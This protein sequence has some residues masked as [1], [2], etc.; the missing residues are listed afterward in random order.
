MYKLKVL[1]ALLIGLVVVPGC[2]KEEPDPGPPKDPNPYTKVIFEFTTNV[3]GADL[4]M[5]TVKYENASGNLYSV[6]NLQFLVGKI[7]LNSW[8]DPDPIY[9]DE[10]HLVDL[11]DPSTWTFSPKDTIKIYDYYNFTLFLGL[12]ED[13]NK[14]GNY[15][16]LDNAGWGWS[17]NNGGGYYTMKMYG[18]YLSTSASTTQLGYDMAVGGNIRKETP[19]DT[20]YI[21]NPI[22][23]TMQGTTGFEIPKG[24][25]L[26][27]IEVRMD[28]NKLFKDNLENANYNLDVYQSNLEE[29]AIGSQIL[30]GNLQY[31]FKLGS[32]TLDAEAEAVE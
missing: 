32:V 20:T 18:N 24:T 14:T 11:S 8:D 12:D 26:V 23:A 6:K 9:I 5:D 4:Q 3:D 19:S 31:C 25:Y 21:P 1:V 30:S 22:Y 13:I 28:V 15:P 27:K 17:P 16:D 29:N 7:R 2:S 10:Y